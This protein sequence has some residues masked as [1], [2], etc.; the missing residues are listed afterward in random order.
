M[1]AL[2]MLL[3]A[4]MV[5]VPGHV[6]P[7]RMPEPDE[8]DPRHDLDRMAAAEAKRARKAA[9][10]AAQFHRQEESA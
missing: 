1:H 9:K 8:R 3:A 7:A 4:G 5:E 2:A 6:V 10:R